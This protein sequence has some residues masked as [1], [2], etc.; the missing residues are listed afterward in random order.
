MEYINEHPE[1]EI[2]TADLAAVA[3]L[4]PRAIQAGF[5]DLLG[6]PPTAYLRGVR[7]DRVH[8]ELAS[9]GSATDVATRWGFFHLSRFAEQYRKRFGALPSETARHPRLL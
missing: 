8:L 1:D 2:T 6:V 7:L 5:R 9:G 4:S 3:A